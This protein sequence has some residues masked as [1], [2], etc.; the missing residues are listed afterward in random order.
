MAETDDVDLACSVTWGSDDPVAEFLKRLPARWAVALLTD[1]AGQAVQLICLKDL[2]QGVR[3]RLDQG[4]GGKRVNWAD[5]VRGVRWTH[6]DSEFEAD[7]TYLKAARQFFP[8]IYQQ[9]VEKNQAWFVHVDPDAQYP[10]YVRSAALIADGGVCLGPFPDRNAAGKLTELIEDAFDL[11]RYYNILTQYPTGNAC[12]YKE[13][14]KCPAPCDGSISIEQYRRMIDISLTALAE[15]GRFIEEQTRRMEQAAAELRFETAAKIKA[16]ISQLSQIGKG[17]LRCARPLGEFAFVTLQRGPR[18]GQ[19]KV[20]LVLPDR[21][22]PVMCIRN[23]GNRGEGFDAQEAVNLL[24]NCAGT[25]RGTQAHADCIG[26]VAR[27]LFSTKAN[28]GVFIPLFELT[29][30]AVVDA[31]VRLSRRAVAAA[32]ENAAASDNSETT[33]KQ[34]P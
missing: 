27:H 23:A 24:L 26:L 19:V 18:K 34:S 13:M 8:A 31:V 10:R 29:E 22:E 3:G 14:G 33:D 17:T 1:G 30:A 6:V 9:I 25:V 11:C 15:P 32:A 7:W 2:R 20:F 5:L 16:Y 4:P 12:A 21:I 28:G